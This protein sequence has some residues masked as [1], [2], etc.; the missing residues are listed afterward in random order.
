MVERRARRVVPHLAWA[1]CTASPRR[2]TSRRCSSSIEVPYLLAADESAEGALQAAWD[3]YFADKP[4]L[5]VLIG[6]DLAMMEALGSHDRPLY[7]RM[8]ELVVSP[9]DLAGIQEL[10]DW[11]AADVIDLQLVCG[12]FPRLAAEVVDGGHRSLDSFLAEQLSDASTPLV[13]N[14]ERSL[15]AEFPANVQAADVLRSI[16]WG[17]RTFVDI[18]TRTG[19]GSA[20]LDRSLRLLVDDK[21]VVE[22]RKPL[23]TEPTKL[24][25]YEVADPY[26]RF[27][28]RFVGPG[29]DEILHGRRSVV[30][31][32]VQRD[33]PSYRGVAVEAVVRASVERLLPDTRLEGASAVGAYWNR[34]G[35]VEVDLVGADRPEAPAAVHFVGSVKWRET[36]PFGRADLAALAHASAEV[37]GAAPG[38][39]L[40]GVSRTGF[41][42]DVALDLALGPEDLVAAWRSPPA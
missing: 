28:L 6:S 21:R 25:L 7:G 14:A 40:V 2:S 19:I 17:L 38:L 41:S 35:D 29:L 10:V 34:R 36:E 37:P 24:T 33:W 39:P 22:R 18:S 4:V 1:R 15:R 26:L 30:H 20:S 9:L 16:G 42:V 27:W 3:R 23:S 31:Q 5:V 8:R 32:R 12:G 13:V 11:T